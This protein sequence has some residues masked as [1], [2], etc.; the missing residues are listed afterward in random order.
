MQSRIATRPKLFPAR[1][2]QEHLLSNAISH[3]SPPASDNIIP[4][5]RSRAQESQG[6]ESSRRFFS[7]LASLPEG[8]PCTSLTLAHPY[9]K[10]QIR[11]SISWSVLLYFKLLYFGFS[12]IREPTTNSDEQ[13][14]WLR[15]NVS[16]EQY[17]PAQSA[18]S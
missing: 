8:N 14:S 3:S 12:G 6:P 1:N 18:L 13:G 10:L 9:E 17:L 7:V 16:S 5:W 2:P 15:Q 4:D 11:L